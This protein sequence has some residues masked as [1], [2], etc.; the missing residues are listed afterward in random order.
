VEP[1]AD[2]LKAKAIQ[3]PNGFGWGLEFP[4]VSR[5]VN[6]PARIP[7]AYTTANAI[8]SLLDQYE[9]CN[10]PLDRE[11]AFLGCQ[12]IIRDLGEFSR[13]GSTWFQYWPD[14]DIPAANVQAILASTFVRA[15]IVLKDINFFD[16]ADRCV[17]VVLATQRSDGSW[18]YSEDGRGWFVDGFHTG[19]ILQGLSEYIQ[20][21]SAIDVTSVQMALQKGMTYFKDHLITSSNMPRYYSDGKVSSDGQNFAQC[22]QT[23]AICATDDNDILRAY[24]VWKNMLKIHKKISDH[25]AQRETALGSVTYLRWTIGPAVLATS[26][27][28]N[29]L[30]GMK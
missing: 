6:V 7:N 22:I 8:R 27:L 15:G 30:L 24:A 10:D 29:A 14:C 1:L 12:C 25:T 26:H 18:Y 9:L 3:T 28:I 13:N 17:K 23:L 11:L 21:R 4:Y 19:F 2:S 20:D 16:L 5:F